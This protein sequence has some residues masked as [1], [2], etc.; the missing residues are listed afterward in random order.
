MPSSPEKAL[1]DI[2][3]AH[4]YSHR[5]IASDSNGSKVIAISERG[6]LC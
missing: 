6:T 2:V 1:V 3:S 4:H 5:A